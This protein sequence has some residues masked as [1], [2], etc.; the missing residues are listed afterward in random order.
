VVLIIG[1]L[2]FK[3]L[4]MTDW[5]RITISTSRRLRKT[6]DMVKR[7]EKNSEREAMAGANEEVQM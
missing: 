6:M 4:P 2:D 3:V 5:S 7:W 1:L